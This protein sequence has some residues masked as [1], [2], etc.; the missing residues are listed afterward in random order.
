MSPE[1][2]KMLPTGKRMGFRCAICNQ[3]THFNKLVVEQHE[4]EC[5]RRPEVKGCPSCG[6]RA[7]CARRG[8]FVTWVRCNDWELGKVEPAGGR[9]RRRGSVSTAKG[10]TIQ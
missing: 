5:A 9:H 2:V 8:A 6:K 7:D 3:F 4:A 10:S 1:S